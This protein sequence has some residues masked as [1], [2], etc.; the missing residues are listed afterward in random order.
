MRNEYQR[1]DL[2]VVIDRIDDR[3][4]VTV[5]GERLPLT[6]GD[7]LDSIAVYLKDLIQRRPAL[8]NVPGRHR[9]LLD[10][11]DED[12]RPFHWEGHLGLDPLPVRV[13]PVRPRILGQ[14]FTLPVRII[15]VDHVPGFLADAVYQ[16]FQNHDRTDVEKAVIVR[17]C[18]LADFPAWQAPFGWPVAEVLDFGRL[19]F[20]HEPERQLSHDAS[21]P[22]TLG[23]IARVAER[24]RTRLIV[25]QA[26]GPAARDLA[27]QLATGL[28]GRGGPAV[29]I[30]TN[31]QSAADFYRDV[32]HDF[33]FDFAF[34]PG[35]GE[36]LFAGSGR[37]E[38][39]R[40]SDIGAG[41]LALQ[42]ERTR[43]AAKAVEKKKARNRLEQIRGGVSG[44]IGIPGAPPEEPSHPRL[45][46]ELASFTQVWTNLE[47]QFHEGDGLLP[48]ARHIDRVRD[49]LP[50]AAAAPAAPAST[51]APRAPSPTRTRSAKKKAAQ[52]RAVNGSLG[53]FGGG[54]W[55][56]LD[57]TRDRLDVGAEYELAIRIGEQDTTLVTAGAVGFA[58]EQIGWKPDQ[59]GIWIEIAVS[60]IGLCLTGAE[61][62]ELWVPPPG[63]G[64]EPIYFPFVVRD[65]GAVSLRYTL[66]YRGNVLQ[67]FRLAALSGAPA[68]KDR[69]L[70]AEALAIPE[71]QVK[72]GATYV[73]RLEYTGEPLDK[74][75][76]APP[77]TLA[78]VI[79]R[80]SGMASVDVKG[81]EFFVSHKSRCLPGYVQRA[82]TALMDIS[83]TTI[84]GIA[85][86]RWPYAFGAPGDPNAGS[87]EKLKES[88]EKL[89]TTGWQLFDQL[90]REPVRKP[91]LDAL[92]AAQEADIGVAHILLENVVPWA[93]VYDR[94][95]TPDVETIDGV[96]VTKD[97]CLAALPGSDGKLPFTTCGTSPS[98]VLKDPAKQV[99]EQTVV[100]PL[101]F[102]GFRHVIDVPPQQTTDGHP[103]GHPPRLAVKAGSSAN[104]AVGVNAVLPRANTHLQ[105]LETLRTEL[106]MHAT[107]FGKARSKAD[108]LLT[109][110]KSK[111]LDVIYFYCHARG[112][113]YDPSIDPPC[114]ELQESDQAAARRLTS[115][116][117]AY[118][119]PWDHDPLVILNGCST[120]G[121]SPD[122][123]S[124]FIEKF[125]LDRGASGVL[126][127]EVP[128]HEPFAGE[129]AIEF[130]RRFL[131]GRPAGQ[132]LLEVRRVLLGR[133]NPL[134]LVYTLYA[135]SRLTLTR[136]GK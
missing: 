76:G 47:F 129:M 25:L 80:G 125:V 108:E 91:M 22:G 10:V 86:E 69:A 50:G 74:A 41:L 73:A 132:S 100:C 93:A 133:K 85:R 95:Y 37:E 64:T 57:P 106:P 5:G 44:Y 110:L 39:L 52:R 97:V 127:T 29:L 6:G 117:F 12:A 107:V 134:G 65:A 104:V 119:V 46:E 105:E 15:A 118:N 135:D 48:M 35:E 121:F 1:S 66:F 31:P 111:D 116:Q 84:P 7:D 136:K 14:P 82:R 112:G 71:Q 131:A 128:V 20:E 23:W 2:H 113:T 99:H 58:D 42:Q 13:S 27:V 45:D 96:A 126:G 51:S 102:W 78:L 115:D 67:S 61:V 49:V 130:L 54:K 90:F 92:E 24:L 120:A 55:S 124:P 59:E 16:V 4:Q 89:A 33:P 70:L 114:L 53:T 123:L 63:A 75:A 68:A 26:K 3:W 30:R 101:H 40:V 87:D 56:Q 60:G 38:L 19:P 28:V 9:V 94:M 32:I 18:A 103:E 17:G 43:A 62:Q 109:A 88:L 79:N 98:C 11:R 83:S 21:R 122:A 77:K 34:Q 36:I 72:E 8:F 81:D